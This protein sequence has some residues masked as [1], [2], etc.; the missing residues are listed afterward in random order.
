MKWIFTISKENHSKLN[1]KMLSRTFTLTVKRIFGRNKTLFG[2]FIFF[3]RAQH[4]EPVN[5]GMKPVNQITMS[6][7]MQLWTFSTN[8]ATAESSTPCQ[9]TNYSLLEFITL[10]NKY[11]AI[12]LVCLRKM[13]AKI[14]PMEIGDITATLEEPH[15]YASDISLYL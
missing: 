7:R 12:L 13:F 8:I 15:R 6:Q 9:A 4:L 5:L 14:S 1:G 11:T 3:W 10:L 2:F